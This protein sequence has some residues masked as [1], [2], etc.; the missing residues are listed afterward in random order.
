MHWTSTATVVDAK[1]RRRFAFVVGSLEQPTAV[2]SFD[3]SVTEIRG[4]GAATTV[5]YTVVLGNGPSIFDTISHQG[6]VQYNS[7]VNDRLD[8]FA[9]S[10]AAMLDAVGVGAQD[11]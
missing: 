11:C 1:P 10:M 5:A 3:L 4:A 7:I 6:A 2:W 8:R 9:A